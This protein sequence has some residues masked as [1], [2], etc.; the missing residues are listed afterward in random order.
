MEKLK[1]ELAL[2]TELSIRA[3][4]AMNTLEVT[5]IESKL[6]IITIA[7]GNLDN[8]HARARSEGD[9][10]TRSNIEPVVN[11]YSRL[12]SQKDVLTIRLKVLHALGTDTHDL[13][14]VR[15]VEI[16]TIR[17]EL[18]RILAE[19]TV[20]EGERD[21]AFSLMR[22]YCPDDGDSGETQVMYN[23]AKEK[24]YD[25]LAL[26]G[27]LHN[28]MDNIYNHFKIRRLCDEDSD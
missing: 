28:R 5:A 17:A 16:D 2:L 11:S 24:F 15:V 22:L 7:L 6:S 20:L 8:R 1:T 12:E 3:N 14:R 26:S 10:Y 19:A 18:T 23:T 25:A 9:G 4:T 21:D 13:V 27:R